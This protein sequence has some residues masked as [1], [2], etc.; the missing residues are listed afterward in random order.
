MAKKKK[1]AK[2]KK[3]RTEPVRRPCRYRV[4]P[5]EVYYD[6]IQ[7]MDF[8]I[9]YTLRAERVERW[10]RDV[11]RDYLDGAE[12]KIVGLDCEFITSRE[13]RENQ[14]AATLQLCVAHETL[15]YHILFADALPRALIELDR[16]SVV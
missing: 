5:T 1:A 4:P 13:G 15:V 8:K 6:T 2:E 11:K 3:E 14:R 10:I 16:K 12:I 7:K 9:T